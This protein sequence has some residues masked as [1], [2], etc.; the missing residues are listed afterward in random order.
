MALLDNIK[1]MC[2]PG[3]PQQVQLTETNLPVILFPPG[4]VSQMFPAFPSWYAR[5]SQ[6]LSYQKGSQSSEMRSQTPSLISE[7]LAIAAQDLCSSYWHPV[8]TMP[9]RPGMSGQV[10]GVLFD[11]PLIFFQ[12]S[13]QKY[14]VWPH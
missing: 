12:G 3:K 14:A 10:T 6:I 9:F 11:V 2:I 7:S 1:N 4:C 5:K 13:E 8:P